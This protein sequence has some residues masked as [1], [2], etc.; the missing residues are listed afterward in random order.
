MHS[1][2]GAHL[3]V[4]F[5]KEEGSHL[6]R[7]CHRADP[8]MGSHWDMCCLSKAEMRNLRTNQ[9]LRRGSTCE[10]QT[11]WRSSEI[12]VEGLCGD[13]RTKLASI[14]RRCSGS[15]SEAQRVEMTLFAERKC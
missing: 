7:I 11:P 2:S 1:V 4:R 6:L 5:E 15:S 10:T 13:A 14:G 12:E 8:D 9:G 3:R